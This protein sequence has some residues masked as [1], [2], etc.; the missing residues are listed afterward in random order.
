M[1]SVRELLNQ[2]WTLFRQAGIADD[3]TIIEHIAA[4]LLQQSGSQSSND[5]LSSRLPPTRSDLDADEIK[6]LLTEATDRAG[7]AAMLFDGHVLF[8]LPG[9]LPGGRYPTP[10]HIV[11]SILRL[12]DVAPAHHLGDLACGS[13]GFL[14]QRAADNHGKTDQTTGVEISP[15][16]ARLAWANAMLHGLTAPRLEIG[17]ALQVC[18]AAGPLARETFDRIVMNPAFGEKIDPKLAEKVLGF[19][20]GSRSETVLMALALH[21]LAPDGRAAILVPSGLLFSNSTGER[22]LRRRLVDELELEAVLSFPRDAFQ[23]YSALQTHLVLVRNRAPE[24]HTRT[25]FFQTERDGYP[26]GR[27]RD[28]TRPPTGA[29]DLPF[30]E[31][32]LAAR[33]TPFDTTFDEAQEPLIGVKKIVAANGALLGVVIEAIKAATLTTVDLFPATDKTPS[34]LLAEGHKTPEAQYMCIQISLDSGEAVTVQDRHG[35]INRLYKPRRQDPSPGTVLFRGNSTGQAVAISKTGRL[36]GVTVAR[37]VLRTHAYDLRPERYAKAPEEAVSSASP[38]AL[39]ASIRHNQREL[40]QRIDELLGRLELA[41]IT[42]Q[43]LP[44]P[45]LTKDGKAIEPFG[46]LNQEQKAVW[47]QVRKKVKKVRDAETPYHTALLFTPEEVN[48]DRDVEVSEVTRTTLDL[49]ERMGVIVPVTIVDPDSGVS[50]AFYRRVTER[51]R[52]PFEA[53]APDSE[54]ESA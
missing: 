21:K 32:V 52:W 18:S 6:R 5:E 13:G 38:A 39:L 29:S 33:S 9:M 48:T 10:R 51:D 17:N 11:T 43:T 47:N 19:R 50:T 44:P 14:V 46:L 26:S 12:A 31:G 45:L 8:R 7:S 54:A 53:A 25:W 30:V 23:P 4:L 20:V 42:G 34:F 3:L 16:W 36:L 28:L 27:G 2:V 22:E 49:L 35:L 1:A 24:R 40:A 15:E 41:P 37:P